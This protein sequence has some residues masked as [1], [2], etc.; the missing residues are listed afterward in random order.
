[1]APGALDAGFREQSFHLILK[2]LAYEI[3]FHNSDN[4][5]FLELWHGLAS[6]NPRMNNFRAGKQ[7]GDN[8]AQESK[9]KKERMYSDA[10]RPWAKRK[11]REFRYVHWRFINHS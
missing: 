5:D 7:R 8:H 2:L 4:K 9:Y 1:M 10:V 11:G 3:V 6:E